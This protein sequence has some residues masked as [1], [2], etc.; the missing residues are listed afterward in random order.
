[1]EEQTNENVNKEQPVQVQEKTETKKEKHKEIKEEVFSNIKL[2]GKYSLTAEVKDAGLKNVIGLK[3][4]VLP[5]SAGRLSQQRLAR[6]RVNIVERLIGHLMVPGHKGKK[7][8]RTSKI[9]S[10]RYYTTYKLVEEAF[11]KISK[12]GQDPIEV[13]IRAIENSAPK[14]EVMGLLIAGQRLSKQVDVSPIRRVDL[15]LR[16]IAQGTFQSSFS[17][18]KASDALSEVLMSAAQNKDVSF[19]VSKRIDTERQAASSR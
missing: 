7:H 18:K 6:T 13:L 10:G 5:K 19:P 9:M 8:L 3:P 2:F 16:W 4:L 11:E 1:M 14:E 15:A 12:A 17:G